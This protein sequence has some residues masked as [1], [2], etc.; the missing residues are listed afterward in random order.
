MKH[1]LQRVL[2]HLAKKTLRAYK[3]KVIAITGSVGK[4]STRH[5]IVAAI[6]STRRVRATGENYN[7]EIG[8]PLTILGERSPGRSF[9]GWLAVLWRGWR[10]SLGGAHNYPEILVLEYGADA[11][12]DIQYLCQIAKPYIAVVTAVGVAHAEFFGTLEDVKEE[13]GSLIR[14]L[15]ADGIA[16]LNA[17]D[18]NVADMCHLAK[19]SVVSYGLGLADITAQDIHVDMR[20]NGE[21]LVGESLSRLTFLLKMGRDSV[22]VVMKDVIGDTHVR[23]VL[24]GAAVALQLGLSPDTIAK[25]VANYVPMPGRL[26]LLPGIKHA[27]L[28]D[29]T[30][31]ASPEAVHA[32]LEVLCSV[33]INPISQRIAAI[34]DMLELGRYSK[35]AHADVGKHVASLPIDLF[36]TVG[37]HARDAA[38]SALE[39]GMAQTQVYTYANSVDAG[40]FLQERMKRGDVLL[41]KGSQ[42]ARMEKIVKELMAEPLKAPEVLVRQYGKWLST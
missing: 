26:R 21:T 40:R 3:P 36:V 19:G 42:G 33:P 15:A 6:G 27:L 7:N 12:G 38:R 39:H 41:V 10:C 11:R 22:P 9:F 1:L 2:A 4:T 32:A 24:A 34:G 37:E 23:S 25:N 17:D 18:G 16:I 14:G 35:Q 31:N 29:D 20:P 30:Y 8:V 5:A 28:I 13:K